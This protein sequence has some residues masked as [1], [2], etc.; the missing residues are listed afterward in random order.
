MSERHRQCS[1]RAKR[2][3]SSPPPGGGVHAT[4]TQ[5]ARARYHS[6]HAASQMLMQSAG[7]SACLAGSWRPMTPLFFCFFRDCKHHTRHAGERK[8]DD[9]RAH[10][11]QSS[12]TTFAE[13]SAP[14]HKTSERAKDDAQQS[15]DRHTQRRAAQSAKRP[16][17][18]E[19]MKYVSPDQPH[20]VSKIVDLDSLV[21]EPNGQLQRGLGSFQRCNHPH[22]LSWHAR[23]EGAIVQERAHARQR[24][25][26]GVLSLAV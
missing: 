11:A 25:M 24:C 4:S 19:N 12:T 22:S 14:L 26:T 8:F 9:T 3:L 15:C 7:P 21:L 13:T 17:M 16:A 20:L 5:A 2:T 23:I 10:G 18:N 1:S 6:V